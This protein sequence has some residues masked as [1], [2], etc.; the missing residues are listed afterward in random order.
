MITA[1][2][3]QHFLI[4]FMTCVYSVGLSLIL[5]FFFQWPYPVWDGF[6]LLPSDLSTMGTD[7]T[8]FT[9][10]IPLVTLIWSIG[11]LLGVISLGQFLYYNCLRIFSGNANTHDSRIKHSCTRCTYCFMM[12]L[13][14]PLTAV[15][16]IYE[17]IVCWDVTL[18]YNCEVDF[19]E[20]SQTDPVWN[21]IQYT[22]ECCGQYNYTDW[23]GRIPGNCCKDTCKT[24]D[25]S[26]AFKKGCLPFINKMFADALRSRTIPLQ[27]L[28]VVS[29]AMVLFL[30]RHN[31]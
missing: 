2:A 24:C 31:A 14:L 12:M 6:P 25:A 20:S 7:S 15:L 27:L 9:Q 16:L 3:K 26:N 4:A 28:Y 11:G 23:G 10:V 17:L 21:K 13:V 19:V 29:L 22:F 5:P 1:L 18:V 8:I 30:F